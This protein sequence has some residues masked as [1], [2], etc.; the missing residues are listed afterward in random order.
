MQQIK[1]NCVSYQ[2]LNTLFTNMYV[3]IQILI[4]KITLL[5]YKYY[6]I[7]F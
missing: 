5:N 1:D 3:G 4:K 2:K 7:F 6:S